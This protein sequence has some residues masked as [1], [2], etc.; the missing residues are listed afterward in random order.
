MSIMTLIYE[1]E[2]ICL[3]SCDSCDTVTLS[4]NVRHTHMSL[5]NESLPLLSVHQLGTLAAR[6]RIQAV[7]A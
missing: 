2:Y 7:I 1:T 3:L 4:Y 5:F 6:D